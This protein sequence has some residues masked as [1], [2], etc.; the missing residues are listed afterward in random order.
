[1]VWKIC[2]EIMKTWQE[3][4]IKWVGKVVR[5]KVR[6]MSRKNEGQKSVQLGMGMGKKMDEPSIM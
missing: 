1:M 4:I 6:Q 5:R 2:E 3:T